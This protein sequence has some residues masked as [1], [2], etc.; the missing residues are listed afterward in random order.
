MIYCRDCDKVILRG[1]A[2]NIGT[3]CNDCRI[4]RQM[5]IFFAPARPATPSGQGALL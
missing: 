5:A 1:E 3:R 4:E 2:E